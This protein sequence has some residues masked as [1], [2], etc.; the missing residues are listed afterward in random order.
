M[1]LDIKQLVDC[2]GVALLPDWFRSKGASIEHRL[3]HDLGMPIYHAA[4]IVSSV[5]PTPVN[6]AGPTAPAA[7]TT[8]W[9]AA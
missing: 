3:A 5:L 6:M 2:D 8:D 7:R 1:K 4:A 9:A